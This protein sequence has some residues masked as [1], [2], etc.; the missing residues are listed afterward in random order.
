MA[1]PFKLD[2]GRKDDLTDAEIDAV[3][4]MYDHFVDETFQSDGGT[5]YTV[6]SARID[7]DGEPALMCVPLTEDGEEIRVNKREHTLPEFK[8]RFLA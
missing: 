3:R 6:T 4:Q 5:E 2:P 1:D 7:E 8:Q